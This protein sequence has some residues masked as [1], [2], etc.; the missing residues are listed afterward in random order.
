MGT[1]NDEHRLVRLYHR[2]LVWDIVK[3]PAITRYAER[4]LAPL[5]GKSVVVYLKK[6]A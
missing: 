1:T 3:T 6:P 4:V 2:L 5:M